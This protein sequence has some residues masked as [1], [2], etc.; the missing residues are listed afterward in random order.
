[1]RS[2]IL[3][4]LLLSALTQTGL[5]QEVA[6][7]LPWI[8]PSARPVI[9]QVDRFYR[10]LNII[11]CTAEVDVKLGDG[12]VD[13]RVGMRA[14][15][16]RPNRVSILAM[17]KNGYFPTNQFISNGTDLFEWSVRRQMF[18]I[19]P[20]G[21]DLQSL[22]ERAFA[23]SAP[24]APVEA[25]LALASDRPIYNLLKLD[26]EPGMVRLVG[27]SELDGVPCNELVVNENGSRV[28]VRAESP[29]WV[30]RYRNS[31]EVALP[32]YLP[33]GA[34][35]IGPDIQ[36]DFKSWSM[37]APDDD[38]WDWLIP[39]GAVRMATMHESAK[40]G[41]EDGFTSLLLAE[42]KP[43]AENGPKLTDTPQ[44]RLERT[45]DGTGLKIGSTAPELELTTLS[46][47]RRFLGELRKDRPAVLVFWLKDDKFSRSGM[48]KLLEALDAYEGPLAVVPIGSGHG[49]GPVRE[50]IAFHPAFAGSYLDAGGAAAETYNVAG[51]PAVVMI[52][53]DGRVV[54]SLVGPNPRLTATVT[55]VCDLLLKSDS[56][57]ESDDSDAPEDS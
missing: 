40:G 50:M 12:V 33:P 47:D 4:A 18:M 42:N 20:T 25:F 55:G 31:P 38:M 57:A 56:D 52:D 53:R 34:R 7:E 54:R 44:R 29:H 43:A 45:G 23:R 15:A 11:A 26:F 21:A 48:R 49:A 13:D 3:P 10:G 9:E 19:G 2:T 14:V 46:G 39:E 16:V 27:K 37:S 36:I 1:M 6:D 30:M 32:R 41:P 35:V 22:Q 24:N 5:G 28:W 8:D 51:V 17:E